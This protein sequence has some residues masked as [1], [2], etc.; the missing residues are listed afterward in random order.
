MTH[1]LLGSPVEP[2]Y[3]VEQSDAVEQSNSV[4][5]S[6]KQS[7]KPWIAIFVRMKQKPIGF[8]LHE[9]Y[10]PSDNMAGYAK[11]LHQGIVGD[12]VG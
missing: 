1:G 8:R 5:P 9:K 3:A 7:A 2:N 11:G 12:Y 6:L 10:K 4:E